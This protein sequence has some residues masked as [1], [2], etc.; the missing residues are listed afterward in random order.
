[1]KPFMFLGATT[2]DGE[3]ADGDAGRG[4]DAPRPSTRTRS[5]A[6]P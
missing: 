1:M 4:A 3:R 2:I 6:M 5:P